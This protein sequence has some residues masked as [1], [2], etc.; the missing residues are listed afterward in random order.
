MGL[1]RV[2]TPAERRPGASLSVSV[3]IPVYQAAGT[4][5]ALA[6]RRPATD[7]GRN[8][9]LGD[10]EVAKDRWMTACGQPLEYHGFTND[11]AVRREAWE[12]CGP[13][14]VNGDLSHPDH[15]FRR[16]VP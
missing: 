10:R 8:R 11:M 3:V 7:R 16:R 12:A 15:R 4:L 2:D 1:D 9:L 13:F 5:A 14:A 6:A